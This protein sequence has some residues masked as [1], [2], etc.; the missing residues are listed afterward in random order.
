MSGGLHYIFHEDVVNAKIKVYVFGPFGT[1][2]WRAALAC[3]DVNLPE[4]ELITK[5]KTFI[6]SI[7]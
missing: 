7:K 4:A 6:N 2:I 5:A 1:T 3:P